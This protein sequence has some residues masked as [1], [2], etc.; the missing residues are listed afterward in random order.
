MVRGSGWISDGG[1]VGFYLFLLV[2]IKSALG[3]DDGAGRIEVEEVELAVFGE[4]LDIFPGVDGIGIVG[5]VFD[6]EA[7]RGYGDAYV[8]IAAGS[9]LVA[10]PVED[11][12]AGERAAKGEEKNA[13]QVGSKE[14]EELEYDKEGEQ[15]QDH[16]HQPAV[17]FGAGVEEIVAVVSF[18]DLAFYVYDIG[19][20]LFALF[21]QDLVDVYIEFDRSSTTF[22]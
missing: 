7:C 16:R 13:V 1:A 10:H 15:Q 19:I 17:F 18:F 3:D 2:G 5:E 21:G 6:I 8:F 14:I 9:T 20:A 12:S 11:G 4:A 22:N